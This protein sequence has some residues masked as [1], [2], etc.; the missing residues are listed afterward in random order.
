MNCGCLRCVSAMTTDSGRQRH[1][2]S[3]VPWYYLNLN[4]CVGLGVAVAALKIVACCRAFGADLVCPLLASQKV[5]SAAVVSLFLTRQQL[6]P[7]LS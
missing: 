7:L 4:Y 2:P 6:P 1:L 3:L 5:K